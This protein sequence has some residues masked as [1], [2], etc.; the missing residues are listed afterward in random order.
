MKLLVYTSYIEISGVILP[1][2]SNIIHVL[3]SLKRLVREKKKTTTKQC[4]SNS[5]E[6]VQVET[7]LIP[8]QA[9]KSKGF[10]L[11]QRCIHT[12]TNMYTYMRLT[13]SIGIYTHTHWINTHR[14]RECISVER[15]VQFI[16]TSYWIDTDYCRN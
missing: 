9:E 11:V 1:I 10:L 7:H 3:S 12:R 6:R 5:W 14:V 13:L 15:L 16:R 8:D 2:S 4:S